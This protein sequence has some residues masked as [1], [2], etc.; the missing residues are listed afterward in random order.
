VRLGGIG[1]TAGGRQH[2]LKILESNVGDH[3][4]SI[5]PQEGPS[6]PFALRY[7]PLY[8]GSL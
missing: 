2:V 3:G 8:I 1:Q 4:G 6:P 5:I 7:A